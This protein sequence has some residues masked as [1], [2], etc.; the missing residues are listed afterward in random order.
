M[1]VSV[2]DPLLDGGLSDEPLSDEPELL[3]EP[4]Q[5]NAMTPKIAAVQN[6]NPRFM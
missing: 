5:D 3:S 1:T 6:I 2:F 4:E